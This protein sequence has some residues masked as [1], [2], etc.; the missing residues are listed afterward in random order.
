MKKQ[1]SAIKGTKDILP[2]EAKK[3]QRVESVTKRILELYAYKEIRTPVFEATELFEKGTGQ[4]TDI[5]IKEM[6]TFKDKAGRSLSLRP[7]YTPSVVRS[8]IENRLYLQPEPLRFYYIGP[9]F[10]YDKPQKGRYRQFHQVD[11]EVFGEE[12]P[13]LDA[14]IV[15]MANYLLRELKVSDTE[16]LVNS[17]G[18]KKCRPSYI[19]DLRT[20]A[21]EAS[22]DLCPDC[23]RK[24]EL[25]PLR[26]FDC[27]IETC[28]E[29]AKT[30]PKI[31]DYLCQECE[32]H[33]NRF[34]DHLVFY[35]IKYKVE[36]RLVRGIDYYTKTT[37][38]IVS[39]K[40]GAQ[41]TLIGGGRY[42]DMMQ[43]FG[44]PDLCA[45]GFAMGLER[46]ISVVPFT[47][48]KD[49][50][51]YLAYLGDESKR[52]GM[53]AVQ[54]LRKESVECLIEYKERSIKNQMSRAN[55][56]GASW[57]LII[58]EEEIKE[59]KYKLKN[60]ASGLQVEGTQDEILKIIR[61]SS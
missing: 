57:V 18:C 21:E 1:I 30:F 27:K 40:L 52:A 7:E 50:F 2:R 55:K 26:I 13:A 23:K 6:Y 34:C 15:E 24:V 44:G 60:M 31:T 37:F 61:E 51:L 14:E 54:F 16:N 48:E 4:T 10:R 59:G 8:I 41:N 53:K 11:I 58:G 45:I 5:V 29:A 25:N 17:V 38:E 43:D 12:D 47:E 56:L 32:D 33:F 46:L 19:K 22:R 28:R 35:G 3:W 39:S 49:E 36:P 9:M 42:D 20:K